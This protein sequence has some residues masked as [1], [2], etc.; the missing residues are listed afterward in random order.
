[1]LPRV[2]PQQG[3][4]CFCQP[5]VVCFD[6]KNTKTT[7]KQ[8]FWNA[9]GRAVVGAKKNWK[10]KIKTLRG[11]FEYYSSIFELRSLKKFSGECCQKFSALAKFFS[12]VALFFKTNN[13]KPQKVLFFA[14]TQK[15][16]RRSEQKLKTETIY[17]FCF[18]LQ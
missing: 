12:I 18:F 7:K 17:S 2:L 5:S 16:A 6:W 1:M 11:P 4:C 15:V 8:Q 14:E 10:S 9:R 13:K 3:K